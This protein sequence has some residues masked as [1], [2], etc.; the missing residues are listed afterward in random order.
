ML[1]F[2]KI[3]N[4]HLENLEK[5]FCFRWTTFLFAVGWFSYFIGIYG[6]YRDVVTDS[7]DLMGFT[8]DLAARKPLL[9]SMLG[10]QNFTNTFGS[11]NAHTVPI[12]VFRRVVQN[13]FHKVFGKRRT[14]GLETFASS[15][16]FSRTLEYSVWIEN[17]NREIL[18]LRT[19]LERIVLSY[20]NLEEKCIVLFRFICVFIFPCVIFKVFSFFR[21]LFTRTIATQ[22][23]ALPTTKPLS[24]PECP[25]STRCLR[26]RFSAK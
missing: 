7:S 1:Y 17:G 20:Y 22:D 9:I 23:P 3:Y 10:M 21:W 11:E 12:N 15:P 4:F 16:W 5:L 8:V 2:R 13:L 24:P 25:P 26:P 19:H 18:Q 6:S 14:E